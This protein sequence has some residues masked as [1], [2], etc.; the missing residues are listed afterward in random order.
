PDGQRAF[1]RATGTA[2]SVKASEDEWFKLMGNRMPLDDVKKVAA[3]ALQHS[4]ELS[5]HT[6]AKWAEILAA[7]RQ[8]VNPLWQNQATAAD[9]L[10][11]G[12]ANLDQI[13]A[14]A[15]QDYQDYQS[16]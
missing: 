4:F 9:A 7:I 1:V 8:A 15:Y 2:S 13:V 14:Q 3:G 5:Q 16:M 10:K 12:K 6:F 11:N